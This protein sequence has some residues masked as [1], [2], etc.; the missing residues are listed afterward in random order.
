MFFSKIISNIFKNR[1]EDAIN[2]DQDLKELLEEGDLLV[3]DM[4]K[5]VINAMISG[6]EVPF[7]ARRY[8][9]VN[10]LSDDEKRYLKIKIVEAILNNKCP[11]E[12]IIK[13]TS[14]NETHPLWDKYLLLKS[15]NNEKRKKLSKKIQSRKIRDIESVISKYGKLNYDKALNGEIFDNMDEELLLLAKGN[16][17]HKESNLIRGKISEVWYYGKYKN[18]MKT[19]SYKFSVRLT[20][21]K[22]KG[23]KNL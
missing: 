5:S 18:R 4:R 14:F 16:P 22:V 9:N 6:Q 11:D 13:L 8:V 15:E 21:G 12:K 17:D 7:Y 1:L 10:A 3:D 20:E 23:W 2:S 19:E